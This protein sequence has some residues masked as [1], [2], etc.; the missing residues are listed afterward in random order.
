MKK[1]VTYPQEDFLFTININQYKILIKCV[2]EQFFKIPEILKFQ[3]KNVGLE[4]ITLTNL[5]KYNFSQ[6]KSNE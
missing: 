5:K 4:T 1:W 6:N 3:K 2:F